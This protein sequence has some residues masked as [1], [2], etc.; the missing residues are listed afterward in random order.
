MSQLSDDL[1]V[2]DAEP[3]SPPASSRRLIDMLV[4]ILCVAA[5]GL[6]L[7]AW[8]VAVAASDTSVEGKVEGGGWGGSGC[9]PTVSY[10]VEGLDYVLRA[11][12][13]TRWC[14]L[15]WLGPARV[16]FE[17]GDPGQA[18]L[19]R[20]GDLPR[21][22]LAISLVLVVAAAFLCTRRRPN[23]DPSAARRGWVA[24]FRGQHGRI[25]RI[26]VVLL[27]VGWLIATAAVVVTGERRSSLDELQA[28]IDRGEVTQIGERGALLAGQRDTSVVRLAWRDGGL[29][30]FATATQYRGRSEEGRAPQGTPGVVIGDLATQLGQS[31][32]QVHVEP[33]LRSTA[34]SAIS[35]APWGWHVFGWPVYLT[36]A[37]LLITVRVLVVAERPRVASRWAWFWLIVGAPI[38]FA[39]A[40][41]ALGGPAGSARRNDQGRPRLG[42]M[43]AFLIAA[44]LTALQQALR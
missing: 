15:H 38:P 8:G 32:V 1:R 43:L 23:A 4:R 29:R 10:T 3:T 6:V 42:G 27:I 24:A 11:E 35:Y 34:P 21:Q 40:Y 36:L 33:D 37:L 44:A 17:P 5:V 9:Y 39:L 7:A 30:Y 19:S 31:G 22:L 13:D 18:R 20:Y 28:A 25:P 12:K 41:L 2:P 14:G 26:L 16:Y